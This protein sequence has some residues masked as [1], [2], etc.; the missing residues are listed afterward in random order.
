MSQSFLFWKPKR[1]I[2]DSAR[3]PVTIISGFLG[4]GKT[5]LLNHIL[6]ES[7][8]A[9]IGLLINDLGEVN[10]DASLVGASLKDF[11]K[12]SSAL[13]ELSSGCICCSIQSELMDA[14]LQLYRKNDLTHIIIEATGVAEPKSIVES[15]RAP[16]VRGVQG[17]DFLR[18]ANLVTVVDAANL[19]NYLGLA[20]ANAKQR[21]HLLEGD[22]RRPL[23]ELLAEQI[24]CADLLV[25]NKTDT[26]DTADLDRLKAILGEV[27]LHAEIRDAQ[28]GRLDPKSILQQER[29]KPKA[30]MNAARWQEMIFQ[31]PD[32]G[33]VS[34]AHPIGASASQGKKSPAPLMPAQPAG[35]HHSEYGLVSVLYRRRRPFDEAKLLRVL[36]GGLPGVIRAKGFYWT[37]RSPD[38][39]G[40]LAIAGRTLRADYICPWWQVVIERGEADLQ[41]VPQKIQRDWHPELGD[42][43]QELVLIGVGIEAADIEARLDACLEGSDHLPHAD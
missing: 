43:R 33:E 14:L 18:I 1:E 10:I 42:R 40:L 13:A 24:E 16:N 31:A 25:I 41:D 21:T 17:T 8:E 27:N 5:T 20:E 7:G 34:G 11:K 12:D 30:T 38:H 35:H 4:A 26:V 36:R 2:K 32:T 9:R 3:I 23:D 29:Y 15:L 22:A 6:G 39:V 37:N 28:F 19:E